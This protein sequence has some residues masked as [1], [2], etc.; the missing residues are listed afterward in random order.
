[1]SNK[2]IL[3]LDF[4]GVV[5]TPLWTSN[6]WSINMPKDNKVNNAEAVALISK[7]CAMFDFDIVVT[8][9]WRLDDNW[10]QCLLNGGLDPQVCIRDKTANLW[11]PQSSLCRGSEIQ[12]WLNEHPEVEM[13]I[14]IDDDITDMLPEHMPHIIHTDEE[15]GFTEWN[16]NQ[17]IDIILDF[18]RKIKK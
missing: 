7:F 5:N 8:S 12:Q 2:R 1:M 9:D 3:F 15:I 17:C 18:E 4:D 16:L 10:R 14:I 11:H 6:G 13:F